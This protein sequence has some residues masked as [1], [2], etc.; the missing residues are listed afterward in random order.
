M[1][2]IISYYKNYWKTKLANL[3]IIRGG[4]SKQIAGDC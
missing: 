4:T 3:G 2:N 1:Y